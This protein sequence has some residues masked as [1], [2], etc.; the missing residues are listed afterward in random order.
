MC[1]SHLSLRAIVQ[2][3][4]EQLQVRNLNHIG[5]TEKY[6]TRFL[7]NKLFFL[8]LFRILCLVSLSMLKTLLLSWC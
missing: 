8:L 3:F 4:I 7:I 6:T 5:E 1:N 2:L